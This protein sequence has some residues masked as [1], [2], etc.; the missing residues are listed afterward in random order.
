MYKVASRLAQNGARRL[1]LADLCERTFDPTDD[2]L[3][4]NLKL[5]VKA[6]DAEI[7]TLPA[8][9]PRRV[10]LGQQKFA[11]CTQMHTIQPKWK[12]PD[13]G[14]FIIRAMREMVPKHQYAMFLKRAEELHAEAQA[15]LAEEQQP[16]S[17]RTDSDA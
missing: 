13:L 3:R 6:I 2:E 9:H 16:P 17:Q 11:L 5:K 4:E 15:L 12:L 14:F 7:A 8:K 1:K 10:E